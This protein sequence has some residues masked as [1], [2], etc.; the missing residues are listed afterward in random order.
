MANY[1]EPAVLI[2]LIKLDCKGS[3][4]LDSKLTWKCNGGTLNNTEVHK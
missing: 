1:Q 2:G 4:S 3:T